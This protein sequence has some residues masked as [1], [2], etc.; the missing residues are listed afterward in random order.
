MPALLMALRYAQDTDLGSVLEL[1]T[2]IPLETN[3][4]D[5]KHSRTQ[6]WEASKSQTCF[7]LLPH[8]L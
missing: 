8:G 5:E 4:T 1:L 3:Y 6:D 7:P 2:L